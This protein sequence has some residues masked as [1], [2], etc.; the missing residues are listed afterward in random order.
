M[1]EHVVLNFRVLT[2]KNISFFR[3]TLISNGMQDK[4]ST[5]LIQKVFPYKY[6]QVKGHKVRNFMFV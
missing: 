1:V 4:M 3:H 5:I 2:G 6:V